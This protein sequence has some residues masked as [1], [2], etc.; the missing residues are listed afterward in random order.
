MWAGSRRLSCRALWNHGITWNQ[1]S[2]KV[3]KDLCLVTLSNFAKVPNGLCFDISSV[4]AYLVFPSTLEGSK[5]K[6]IVQAQVES[7]ESLESGDCKG[8]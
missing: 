1:R 2:A 7:L 8:S 6:E 4:F 3:R 5:R